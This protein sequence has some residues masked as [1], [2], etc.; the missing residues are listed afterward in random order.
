MGPAWLAHRSAWVSCWI[1]HLIQL[2]KAGSHIVA[3]HRSPLLAAEKRQIHFCSPVSGT[4]E[5]MFSVKGNP[6]VKILHALSGYG[7]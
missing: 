2:E 7:Y 3:R 1:I 5:K 6:A 4:D